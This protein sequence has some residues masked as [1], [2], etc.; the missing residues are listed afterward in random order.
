MNI[1]DFGL[2]RDDATNYRVSFPQKRVSGIFYKANNPI[3]YL[4]FLESHY[5]FYILTLFFYN[6]VTEILKKS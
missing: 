3:F 4:I 5:F 2:R 6:I 1:L